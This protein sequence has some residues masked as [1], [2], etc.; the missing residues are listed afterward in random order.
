MVYLLTKIFF[1]LLALDQV[2]FIFE[3]LSILN[4][5]SFSPLTE[6]NYILGLLTILILIARLFILFNGYPRYVSI[7]LFI[8]II[9][10][11]AVPYIS[12]KLTS[13]KLLSG[14]TFGLWFVNLVFTL[15][16][17]IPPIIY[18]GEGYYFLNQFVILDLFSLA[19]LLSLG[20]CVIYREKKMKST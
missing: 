16:A 18:F 19:S 6:I 12:Y 4:N 2:V 7:L 1:G 20:Y 17:N 15:I 14:I 3:V 10:V 8:P 5:S 13:S 11:F 9:N